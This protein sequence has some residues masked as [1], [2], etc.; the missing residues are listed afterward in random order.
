M[1]KSH[2]IFASA[3]AV[4]A[5]WFSVCQ[6]RGQSGD[7]I[8]KNTVSSPRLT[9]AYPGTVVHDQ[10]QVATLYPV[11]TNL[12]LV[13]NGKTPDYWRQEGAAPLIAGWRPMDLLPGTHEIS[14]TFLER[15][16]SGLSSAYSARPLTVN[17]DMK[18][19]H[20][21]RVNYARNG[22]GT[23]SMYIEEDVS[24]ATKNN[25][26]K[27][28]NRI[29][30]QLRKTPEY[31]EPMSD[32]ACGPRQAF[33]MVPAGVSAAKLERNILEALATKKRV[34]II[35]KQDP[36][37]LQ[38]RHADPGGSASIMIKYNAGRVDIYSKEISQNWLTGITRPLVRYLGKKEQVDQ[39]R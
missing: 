4:G 26:I 24:D 29:I 7:E 14:A 22:D 17:L 15:H 38:A 2:L 13:V 18:A 6:S 3:L 34:W 21:Y 10:S 8:W 12:F 11:N 25:I 20:F 39:G 19:G 35:D 30:A 9:F 33:V 37:M 27:G 5:F 28:R 1:K 36:G 23:W 32:S 31:F 16:G